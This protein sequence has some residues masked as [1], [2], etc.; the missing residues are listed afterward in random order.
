MH[1]YLPNHVHHQDDV[2]NNE[3]VVCV[4]EDLVVGHAVINYKTIRVY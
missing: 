3:E 1:C 4:P 2:E